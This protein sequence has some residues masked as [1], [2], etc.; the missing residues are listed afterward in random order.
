M[1]FAEIPNKGKREPLQ[2]I[3]HLRERITTHL[4]NVNPE[5]LLSKGNTR[6]KS[7]AKIDSRCKDRKFQAG[8]C[9]ACLNPSIQEYA[10]IC[11]GKYLSLRP[12]WSTK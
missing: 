7:G 2:T 6:T 5:L 1:T 8:H 3:S 12:A 4:K 10:V 11:R 9:C